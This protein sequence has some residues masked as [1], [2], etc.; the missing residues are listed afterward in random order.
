MEGNRMSKAKTRASHKNTAANHAK[1]DLLLA[2]VALVAFVGIS[3]GMF[4][5]L[6]PHAKPPVVLD[7]ATLPKGEK[8]IALTIVHT[9][10][11]WGYLEGCG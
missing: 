8:Q 4:T 5:L 1:R 9:N 2:V 6:N 3:L 11:T 10:D 7:E